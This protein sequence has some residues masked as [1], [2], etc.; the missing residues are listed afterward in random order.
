MLGYVAM[1]RT[2]K[3]KIIPVLLVAIFLFSG[4]SKNKTYTSIPTYEEGEEYASGNL[5]TFSTSGNAFGF[6]IKN[7]SIAKKSLFATG[8]SLFNNP[9]VAAPASTTARDGL[10]PT[11]NA[12]ACANCHAKDGRG[13]PML[14]GESSKGF[15]MRISLPGAA[16][17]KAPFPVPNY[18]NQ[19]QDRSNPSASFEAKE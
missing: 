13:R 6:E 17:N 3:E 11:F 2:I 7:L 5:G 18:G 8:N 19:I 9:W 10:G 1:L 14:T 15:L 12:V 4:C 16:E